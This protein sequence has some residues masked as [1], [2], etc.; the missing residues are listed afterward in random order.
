MCTVTSDNK[1]GILIVHIK[2]AFIV[3]IVSS[4]DV[5]SYFLILLV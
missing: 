4:Y 3:L 2:N 1:F 5:F